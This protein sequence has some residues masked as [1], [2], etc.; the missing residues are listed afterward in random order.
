MIKLLSPLSRVDEVEDLISA[1]ADEFYCGVLPEEWNGKYT[2]S[3]SINRRQEDNSIL[4]TS[5]HFKCFE[6]LV[7]GFGY[8]LINANRIWQIRILH[9]FPLL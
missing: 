2:V 8:Y 3:A 9:R 7:F 5:P 4:G 1:G 6:D